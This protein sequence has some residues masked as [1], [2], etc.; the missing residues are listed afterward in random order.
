MLSGSAAHNSEDPRMSTMEATS[1]SPQPSAC[2]ARTD[3][4]RAPINA[5]MAPEEKIR[6]LRQMVRIRHFEERSLKAYN[7]G[8]IAGFL[9]LY[10]GQ[11]ALAVGSMTSQHGTNCL[12]KSQLN[13]TC[14]WLYLS[15]RS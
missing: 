15:F 4:A 5:S 8:A 1:K 14:K 10:I 13:Y 7:E 3:Y 11:E 9:H 12:P 6:L 2:A